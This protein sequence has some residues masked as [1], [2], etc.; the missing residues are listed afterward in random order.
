VIEWIEFGFA[1]SVVARFD[2]GLDLGFGPSWNAATDAERDAVAE[3]RA[4]RPAATLTP[5]LARDL[6]FS[7]TWPV[8]NG[9]V[10]LAGGHVRAA[11][12]PGL[13]AAVDDI[14]D[15]EAFEKTLATVERPPRRIPYTLLI[16]TPSGAAVEGV[17]FRSFPPSFLLK[18][19][20]GLSLS[21]I[22]HEPYNRPLDPALLRDRITL[23]AHRLAPIRV[24]E[25][26]ISVREVGH[27]AGE[28][29]PERYRDDDPAEQDPLVIAAADLPAVIRAM[30]AQEAA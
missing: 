15:R 13:I 24:R 23:P 30:T 5:I 12:L 2:N 20:N 14:P 4:T 25:V 26:E 11:D 1:A 27:G 7:V 29:A 6:V 3:A 9:S 17:L 21:V 10:P 28:F 19:A 16:P 22:P 18:V 8:T